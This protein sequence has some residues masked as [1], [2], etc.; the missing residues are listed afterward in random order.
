MITAIVTIA[1][2]AA[3]CLAGCLFV[4]YKVDRILDGAWTDGEEEWP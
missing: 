1:L 4:I 3:L 2:T